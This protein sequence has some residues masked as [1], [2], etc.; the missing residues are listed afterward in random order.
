MERF[1]RIF[2]GDLVTQVCTVFA[3]AM[4][5]TAVVFI[6]VYPRLFRLTV[7]NLRRNILRTLLTCLATV[8]LVFM[9]TMIWTVINFLDRAMEEKSTDIK[10]IVTERWQLP[11]QMPLTHAQYLDPHN[12]KFLPELQGLVK[13]GDFMTW[14]FYGGTP[15]PK[16]MSPEYFVFF[17]CMDPDHIIPMMEDLDTLDPKLVERLKKSRYGC[18][19]G[20]ERL[21]KLGKKVGDR[22]ALTSFNYK[23]IDLDFE[24]VGE[25]PKGRYGLSGIMNAEY[26]NQAFETY[27]RA[28]NG[29][30]HVLDNKRLNLIWLRVPDQAGYEKVAGIIESSSVFGDR[31]VKCETA[32]SLVGSF[33]DAYRDLLLIV[34]YFLVPTFLAIMALVVANSISITVRERRTEI[35][36][37]K[38]LGYRP[39]QIMALVLGE[40]LLVGGTIGLATSAITWACVNY[41]FGGFNFPIGFFP[42]FLIPLQALAWGTAMGF[43]TA[44]A[45]SALPAW[46]ARRVRVAEVFAKVA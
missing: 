46:T 24:I 37:L 38:V 29:Q 25:L 31:P 22:F 21:A 12:S 36:V 39:G 41:G 5:V 45:G 16:K 15:D 35:A 18:L 28:R 33:M 19:L 11:S 14:S 40:A 43:F 4:L 20:P 2:F 1:T 34:K 26:F 9:V 13:P 32:S 42:T 17:F 23:G 6:A 7:K 8:V 10:L 30:R 44:L 3:C 27:A